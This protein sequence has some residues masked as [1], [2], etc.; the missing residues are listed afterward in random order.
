MKYFTPSSVAPI[1]VFTTLCAHAQEPLP[2]TRCPPAA[3]LTLERGHLAGVDW[4]EYDSGK[5]HS[6]A[7][8]NHSLVIDATID[9]RADQTASSAS[10]SVFTAGSKPG[11][12][13]VND[14]GEGAIYWSPM[15][16]SSVEQALARARALGQTSAT[17][18]GASLFSA[19]RVELTV[20]RLDAT[21]W[22]ID[23]RDKHYEV[24]TDE[25]GCMVAATLPDFGV[26]IER[27]T[28]FARTD[29]LLW[30]P[31]GAPPDHAYQALD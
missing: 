12:R 4:L 10:M 5:A 20:K 14:L 11:G 9:L 25:Q 26:T 19:N 21:D 16:V 6:Y 8:L 29:Y 1:L 22:T 27:R 30:S 31:Y 28:G 2:D 15:L 13:T 18:P 23:Y 7:V 3:F 24:L 17:I